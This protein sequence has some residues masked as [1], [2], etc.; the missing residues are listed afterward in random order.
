MAL[1]LRWHA[2]PRGALVGQWSMRDRQAR[3]GT[4][5]TSFRGGWQGT[6]CSRQPLSSFLRSAGY[7]C[8]PL[9]TAP[10]TS[11]LQ[12]QTRSTF[13]P[14]FRSLMRGERLHPLCSQGP[15]KLLR[16]SVFLQQA[17][18]PKL[19]KEKRREQPVHKPGEREKKVGTPPATNSSAPLMH[20]K[21]IK[22]LHSTNTRIF[23]CPSYPRRTS[24][25][26]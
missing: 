4:T 5:P 15:D 10:P 25:R 19:G 8:M 17:R 12:I 22:I 3:S 11:F 9:S 1:G 6:T 18:P 21:K 20:V 23:R 2:L 26:G 7:R 16:H 13:R 24:T 14:A